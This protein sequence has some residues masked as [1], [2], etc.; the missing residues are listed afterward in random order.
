MAK[1][2]TKSQVQSLKKDAE[3]QKIIS[4]DIELKRLF[5]APRRTRDDRITELA[6]ALGGAAEI[7]SGRISAPTAGILLILGTLES[8]LLDPDA[9]ARI[10]DA[11]IAFFVFINGRA[12]LDYAADMSDIERVANGSC[13]DVGVD[14]LEAWKLMKDLVNDSF[15]GLERIPES[16]GEPQKCRFDLGWFSSIT[17]RV[18]DAANVTAEYAGWKMPLALATHYIVANHQ[19]NGGKVYEPN[20]G[21]KVLD[22]MNEL[23]VKRIQE[24]RYR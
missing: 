4:E 19:K 6:L 7:G 24:K 23:I 10:I 18:A 20:S 21:K 8:P 17:S 15:T 16:G 22:R 2:F 12:A 13:A 3:F 5:A 11:D 14:P 9:T 1:K